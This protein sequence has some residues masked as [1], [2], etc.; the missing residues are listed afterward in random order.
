[1]ASGILKDLADGA[2]RLAGI[3]KEISDLEFNKQIVELGQL[4]VSA[5]AE[6]LDLQRENLEIKSKF[7]DLQKRSKQSADLI[8]I[9]GFKYDERDG[10]P[11]GLPFCPACEVREE[12]YYRL[13]RA[14]DWYSQCP[15]CN[16]SFN[17][18][19]NGRVHENEPD[20]S[21]TY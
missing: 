19:Q 21:H 11:V 18:G 2:R 1:M 10:K 12:K 8:E 6:I 7:E 16:T 13:T 5:Q 9:H 3:K 14:N 20:L 15:N 4:L 17:A